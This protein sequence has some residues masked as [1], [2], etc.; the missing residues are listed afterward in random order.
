MPFQTF[1]IYAANGSVIPV[2]PGLPSQSGGQVVTSEKNETGT[3]VT[4]TSGVEGGQIEGGVEGGQIGEASINITTQVQGGAPG[5]PNEAAHPGIY[6]GA[7][8]YNRAVPY[9]I[10]PAQYNSHIVARHKEFLDSRGL[11]RVRK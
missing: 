5:A 6:H 10:P 8:V 11:S 2:Q 4:S 7:F 3:N 1:N 9:Y